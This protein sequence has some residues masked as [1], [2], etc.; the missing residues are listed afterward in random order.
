M[1]MVDFF[2]SFLVCFWAA[3]RRKGH[4]RRIDA[5]VSSG[6]ILSTQTVRNEGKL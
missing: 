6:V 4:R 3:G 5:F 2:G 1:L